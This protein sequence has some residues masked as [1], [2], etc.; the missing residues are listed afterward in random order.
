[1][2]GEG[3]FLE[4]V[5][6]KLA[7]PATQKPTAPTKTELLRQLITTDKITLHSTKDT[8]NSRAQ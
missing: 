2:F 6:V 1:M 5:G 4:H 8:K 7:A 3:T